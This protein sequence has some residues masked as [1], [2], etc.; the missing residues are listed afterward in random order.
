VCVLVYC[1][2]IGEC[3]NVLL[4]DSFVSK[5]VDS[6]LGVCSDCGEVGVQS[7]MLPNKTEYADSEWRCLYCHPDSDSEDDYESD[8]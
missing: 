4:T 6:F 7:N 2:V 1:F 8:G 3:S 5:H